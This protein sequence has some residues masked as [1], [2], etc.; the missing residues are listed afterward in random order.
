MVQDTEQ[1]FFSVRTELFLCFFSFLDFYGDLINFRE[2]QVTCDMHNARTSAIILLSL[3]KIASAYLFQI[4][5][6]K[7]CDYLLIYMK[8]FD[9]VKQKKPRRITQSGKNGAIN[10]A[11]QGTCVIFKLKI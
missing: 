3:K 10:C 6:E 5:Q 2:I 8:K 7:L 11:M 1:T 9:M 4:A